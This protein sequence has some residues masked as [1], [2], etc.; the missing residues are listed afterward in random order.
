MRILAFSSRF[1][2]YA[3]FQNVHNNVDGNLANDLKVVLFSYQ[4]YPILYNFSVFDFCVSWSTI[5]EIQLASQC[6]PIL[7][8]VT[9]YWQGNAD[10]AIDLERNVIYAWKRQWNGARSCQLIEMNCSN[11]KFSGFDW[12]SLS[13]SAALW[14]DKRIGREDLWFMGE[15]DLWLCLVHP[16]NGSRKAIFRH[17]PLDIPVTIGDAGEDEARSLYVSWESWHLS[18]RGLS[19]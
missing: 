18:A 16:I 12:K 19:Y 2:F 15:M 5:W 17:C 4:I 7:S 14:K 10:K 3:I 11:S 9:W 6:H 1:F 13:L 8:I